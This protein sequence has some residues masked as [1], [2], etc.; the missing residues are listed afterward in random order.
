MVQANIIAAKES[1]CTIVESQALPTDST[2][3]S[4]PLENEAPLDS[5]TSTVD[6]APAAE[7]KNS[8]GD[9]DHDETAD[10]SSISLVT[11]ATPSDGSHNEKTVDERSDEEQPES[12]ARRG[13]LRQSRLALL[14]NRAAKPSSA[15]HGEFGAL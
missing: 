4:A 14:R 10:S 13:S 12:P 15:R 6:D 5:T 9:D 2:P 3:S 8:E 1:E 11:L 7:L